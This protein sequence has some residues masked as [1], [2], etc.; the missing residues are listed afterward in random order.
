MERKLGLADAYFVVM[1][2]VTE[3]KAIPARS[4]VRDRFGPGAACRAAVPHLG[5]DDREMRLLGSAGHGTCVRDNGSERV[6]LRCGCVRRTDRPTDNCNPPPLAPH[7]PRLDQEEQRHEQCVRVDSP[8]SSLKRGASGRPDPS[9]GPDGPAII[10]ASHRC[11]K[12]L[13]AVR[14]FAAAAPPGPRPPIDRRITQP[15]RLSAVY[16]HERSIHKRAMRS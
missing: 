2:S 9:L 10:P 13:T 5:S 4:R 12:T 14:V 15:V 6:P 16:L 11:R 3:C 1:D 8:E 7:S